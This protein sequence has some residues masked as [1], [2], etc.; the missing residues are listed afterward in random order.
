MV[1]NSPPVP[2]AQ[3]S[4][5]ASGVLLAALM[6][7]G[8]AA[9]AALVPATATAESAPEKSTIAIQYGTYEDRQP[10]FDRVTV[11]AP[12]VYVQVPVAN[13]WAIAGSWVGD[14][15]S[16]ASPRWHTERSSASRMS[17]YRKAGDIKVTRYLPRAAL[18]ASLAYSD[19]HDYTSRAL[20]LEARWSGDDNN[21]TW[22]VGYGRAL[23]K[24][25]NTGSG[26]NTA[27]DQHRRTH[28][29]MAGV[30]QVLTPTDIVQLNLTRSMG[31][32][33]YNDPYKT[34]DQRPDHRDAWIAVLRWNHYLGQAD[35][36][37]RSNYRYYTDTFGIRSHTVGIEWA[38]PLGRWTITPGVRYTTQRAASFYL[39]PVL[40][41]QGRYD[42][43]AT[44]ASAAGITGNKSFDTRLGSFGAATLSAK[45]GYAIAP[46]TV[47]SIKFEQYQQRSG[48]RLGGS[49]SP[50][51]APLHA[52]FLQVGLTHQF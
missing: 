33:Y 37:L 39:D 6:L 5:R 29:L 41:A 11:H 28:E 16:G 48:L 20:G 40:D 27:I 43:G 46:E 7:P 18:S 45:V 22:I 30:T 17:D 23:D 2:P 10:G 42:T 35:A 15:V 51:I 25:D 44:L 47:I 14:S 1:T 49:G 8:L 38:Q 13:D 34:F 3:R 36:A 52:R 26:I 21:R 24:I 31:T 32:G 12:Q 9:L 4:Q 50:D 19:E